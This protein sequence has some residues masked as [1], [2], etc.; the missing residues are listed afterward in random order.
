MQGPK[1]QT[2]NNEVVSLIEVSSGVVGVS[3]KAV[4]FSTLKTLA[5]DAVATLGTGDK[6]KLG[7]HGIVIEKDKVAS[8]HA[9]KG[10]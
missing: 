4:F 9:V 5:P 3:D 6:A 1:N 2:V 8:V 10:R 7:E